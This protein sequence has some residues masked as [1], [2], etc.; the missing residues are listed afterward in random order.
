MMLAILGL[1]LPLVGLMIGAYFTRNREMEKARKDRISQ[2]YATYLDAV[3]RNA[4][5]RSSRA[6]YKMVMGQELDKEEMATF[7]ENNAR[8]VNAHSNLVIY[9]SKE[10][11]GALSSFYDSG[12]DPRNP[13]S[14][15]AY[16]ALVKAMRHDSDAEDYEA[17]GTHVDNILITGPQRR[18]EVMAKNP[19]VF[20]P[21]GPRS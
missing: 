21:P 6:M 5:P 7:E 18:Q 12:A 8:F 4:G 16:I 9:G 20:Q 19:A 1:L 15:Q 10:V 17:F 11:I 14:R 13:A 2:A 3:A